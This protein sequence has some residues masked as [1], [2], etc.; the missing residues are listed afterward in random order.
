M[1]KQTLCIHPL[2]AQCHRAPHSLPKA[3]G[4]KGN[5]KRNRPTQSRIRVSA[6]YTSTPCN[7]AMVS[8][9][10]KRACKNVRCGSRTRTVV[11]EVGGEEEDEQIINTSR[12]ATKREGEREGERQ[13][14]R[15][16]RRREGQTQGAERQSCV[17]THQA[18]WQLRTV[19]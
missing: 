16:E 1:V 9:L 19:S 15:G 11:C 10:R 17:S 3:G 12:Q 4:K 6:H 8:V 14:K 2:C 18:E 5:N 7:S 13:A